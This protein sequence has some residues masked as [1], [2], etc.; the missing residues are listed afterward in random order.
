MD[1]PRIDRRTETVRAPEHGP[2]KRHVF[3]VKSENQTEC[4]LR[5]PTS[6]LLTSWQWTSGRVGEVVA[7][8]GE[9]EIVIRETQPR[10]PMEEWWPS[11]L[12]YHSPPTEGMTR[13]RPTP[14]PVTRRR[15]KHFT[16][17]SGHGRETAPKIW[18]GSELYSPNVT[19][20]CTTHY[21]TSVLYRTVSDRTGPQGLDGLRRD[22]SGKV[23]TYG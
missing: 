14:P 17:V 13:S 21:L 23:H 8:V 18:K 22:S 20:P 9:R 6:I 10:V 4:Y 1:V 5:V 11:T 15:P 2:T 7:G 12:H 19:L 16:P 3:E